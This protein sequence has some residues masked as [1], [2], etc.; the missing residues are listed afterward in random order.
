MKCAS[1]GISVFKT[2]LAR[3][4]PKGEIPA[5]WWCE[6]CLREKEPE[7]AK[8]IK[9]DELPVIE[10]LVNTFYFGLN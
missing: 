9:E 7:L 3:V 10:G 6:K 8:N 4:S 5:V 1:C 2:P